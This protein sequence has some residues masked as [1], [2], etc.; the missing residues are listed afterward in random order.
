MVR[1]VNGSVSQC[2]VSW[3]DSTQF[4]TVEY[5]LLVNVQRKTK[6]GIKNS[7]VVYRVSN[8]QLVNDQSLVWPLRT[9][10]KGKPGNGRECVNVPCACWS[11]VQNLLI[12]TMAV[13]GQWRSF[14]IPG[15]LVFMRC[16]M[17]VPTWT[18]QEI[19]RFETNSNIARPNANEMSRFTVLRIVNRSTVRHVI[20]VAVVLRKA[21]CRKIGRLRVKIAFIVSMN[22]W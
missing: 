20:T 3:K 16:Y 6:L 19:T 13:F 1:L 10:R 9:F 22:W 7:M 4:R 14:P 2:S 18:C 12:H 8:S 15:S 17:V 11:V 21:M 5:T